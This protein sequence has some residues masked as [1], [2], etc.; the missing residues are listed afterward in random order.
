MRP[1]HATKPA[2]LTRRRWDMRLRRYARGTRTGAQLALDVIEGGVADVLAVHHVDDVLADV[3]GVIADALERAH[4]PHDIQRAANGARVFHHESDALTLDRFVLLVHQ[5]VLARDAQRGFHIHARK[6][7]EGIV[8][9]LRH[10]AAKVLDLAVLVRRALHGREAR[11]DVADLLALVADTLEVGDGLDDGDDHP[12]VAGR[13]SARGEDAAAF[14]VDG[15]LHVVHLMIV[16]G[17]CFAKG[18]VAFDQR[19][20]RL[21]QLLLDEAAHAEHLAAH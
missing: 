12:Q 13:R 7:I 6:G 1:T 20:D 15:D 10:Y 2:T 4:H 18:A 21:L 16:H 5:T 19:S 9:H 11:G 17:H 8:H 3:L 14:L